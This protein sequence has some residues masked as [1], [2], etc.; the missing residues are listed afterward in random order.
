MRNKKY[1]DKEFE[2]FYGNIDKMIW[3]KTKKSLP[4]ISARVNQEKETELNH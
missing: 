1:E 4:E 3:L 2:E